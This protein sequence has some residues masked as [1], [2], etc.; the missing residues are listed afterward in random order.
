MGGGWCGRG[1]WVVGG[2]WWVF[3]TNSATCRVL[4]R[5]LL[6]HWEAAAWLRR[7]KFRLLYRKLHR[8]ALGEMV[9]PAINVVPTVTNAAAAANA[10]D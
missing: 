5:G 3:G 10:G 8:L 2:G 4:R 1:W 6:L 9:R 7:H